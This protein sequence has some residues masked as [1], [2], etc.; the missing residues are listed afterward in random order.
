MS[1]GSSPGTSEISRFSTRAGWQAAARRPPLIADRC[2]RTQFISPMV[3]PERSSARFSACLSASVRPA[4]GIGSSAEPPPEIRHSTRSSAPRP[5]T[6]S[7]MRARRGE[8]VV[9]GHR[10]RGLEDL[11]PFATDRVAVARDDEPRAAAPATPAPAPGPSPP[12]PCPRR[13]RP[14]GRPA[15]AA[16][17]AGCRSPAAPT[18]S[19]RRTS[20]AAAPAARRRMS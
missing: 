1:I 18:R 10:V 20:A 14:A 3:A 12:R 13:S 19:P 5:C 2:R 7:S 8:P 15:A 17:E 16:G 11:D 4:A 6:V 9:V